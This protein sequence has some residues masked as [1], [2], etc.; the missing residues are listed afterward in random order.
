M[1]DKGKKVNRSSTGT[2]NLDRRVAKPANRK[3]KVK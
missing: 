3:G 2:N 1:K